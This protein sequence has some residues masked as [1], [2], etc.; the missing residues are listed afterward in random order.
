MLLLHHM[1]RRVGLFVQ[2]IEKVEPPKVRLSCSACDSPVAHSDRV[3]ADLRYRSRTRP[4]KKEAAPSLIRPSKKL[5]AAVGIKVLISKA[6]S[7]AEGHRLLAGGSAQ[8]AHGVCATHG[9]SRSP[10]FD[11]GRPM[12]SRGA[13]ASAWPA[14]GVRG[15]P[16]WLICLADGSLLAHVRPLCQIVITLPQ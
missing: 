16:I 2:L 5:A 6:A 4:R 3:L 12:S 8:A 7:G 15:M 1:L 10:G 11:A 13:H 9:C 14:G